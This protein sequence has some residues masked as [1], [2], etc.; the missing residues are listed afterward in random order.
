[1]SPELIAVIV[2]DLTGDELFR[3]PLGPGEAP[4]VPLRDGFAVR[5]GAG[6]EVRTPSGSERLHTLSGG[7]QVVLPGQARH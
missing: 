4:L 5:A 1:M 7:A 6:V 2:F 3:V